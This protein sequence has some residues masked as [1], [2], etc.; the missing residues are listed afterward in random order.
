MLIFTKKIIWYKNLRFQMVLETVKLQ[1]MLSLFQ[2]EQRVDLI[3]SLENLSRKENSFW[4]K[5]V[6]DWSSKPWT[7]IRARSKP[8]SETKISSKSVKMDEKNK[9]RSVSLKHEEQAQL[10]FSHLYLECLSFPRMEALS[11]LQ[12]DDA[13]RLKI[14]PDFFQIR[15]KFFH[16]FFAVDTLALEEVILNDF[17][18]T[19]FG[20]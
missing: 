2:F 9:Q 19:N 4:M 5:I 14:R 13:E 3:S 17:S 18:L 12:S 20:I 6:K 11:I 10:E 16:F 8:G 7:V 1:K 15:S